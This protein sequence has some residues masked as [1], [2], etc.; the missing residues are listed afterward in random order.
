MED[1][2]F[3]LNRYRGREPLGSEPDPRFSF[4]NERTALAWLRTGLGCIACAVALDHLAQMNAALTVA[5][6]ITLAILGAACGLQ[7]W[8]GWTAAERALRL[9]RPL[10]RSRT[11]LAVALGI[12]LVAVAAAIGLSL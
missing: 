7:A 5:L 10:P 1:P 9:Q 8:A 3:Q 12:V 11:H 6:A 2:M 4:A